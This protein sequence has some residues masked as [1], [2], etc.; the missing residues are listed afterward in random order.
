MV[1]E[2]DAETDV[3]VGVSNW[4]IAIAVRNRVVA[5]VVVE[6]TTTKHSSISVF[7]L[8]LF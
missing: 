6:A 5:T 2:H 8:S 1:L 7:D 3:D 4:I